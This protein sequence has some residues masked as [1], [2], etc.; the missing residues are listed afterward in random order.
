MLP[1]EIH[2]PFP[3]YPP[4]LLARRIQA[5]V[6]LRLKIATDGTVAEATVHR[7]SGYVAMDQAA[8]AGVKSWKFKPAMKNGEAVSRR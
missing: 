6:V 8:L 2:S 5:T 1:S 7:T 3:A 4:E